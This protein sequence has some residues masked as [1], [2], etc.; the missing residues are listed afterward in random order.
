MYKLSIKIKIKIF[1]C[2]SVY[3]TCLSKSS[4]FFALVL[5]H[6]CAHLL[7]FFSLF[8]SLLAQKNNSSPKKV[9]DKIT[10]VSI[11]FVWCEDF[12]TAIIFVLNAESVIWCARKKHFNKFNSA[13]SSTHTSKSHSARSCNSS[14]I[15]IFNSHNVIVVSAA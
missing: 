9:V 14:L 11:F 6:H 5:Y 7:S 1:V 10:K 13:F 2:V 4:I 3:F 15:V 12:T 8:I